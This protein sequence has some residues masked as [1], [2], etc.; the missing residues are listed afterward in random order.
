MGVPDCDAVAVGVALSEDVLV[1]LGVPEK[2]PVADE[3]APIVREP[4]GEKVGEALRERVLLGDGVGV[5]LIEGVPGPD[6]VAEGDAVGEGV[7]LIDFVL[8]ALS[9]AVPDGVLLALPPVESVVVAVA[10]VVGV[11]LGDIEAL[12]L[13][14]ADSET[15]VDPVGDPVPVGVGVCEDE[16]DPLTEIVA[17]GEVE[18]VEADVHEM[19]GVP[20]AD[21]RRESV[22][23]GVCDSDAEGFVLALGV[24]DNE[25]VVVGLGEGVREL[26]GV[27][28]T[29]G[30]GD[31]LESLVLDGVCEFEDVSEALAPA[32]TEAVAVLDNDRESVSVEDGVSDG[33][34][35][36]DPV[37]E[38][39]WVLLA[40]GI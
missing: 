11:G 1:V 29:V 6:T 23:V 35:V 3:L 26:E 27:P 7:P 28:E 32:V 22:V 20:L 16:G 30:V 19:E 15:V 25:R 4:V 34:G 17:E 31:E 38:G 40:D 39:V 5:E 37:P 18:G 9:G 36:L 14:V 2:L 8:V 21:A 12:S 24:L 33:V 13:P 10:D